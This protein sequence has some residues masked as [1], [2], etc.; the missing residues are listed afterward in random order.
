MAIDFMVRYWTTPQQKQL[1]KVQTKAIVKIK[2][3]LDR[4]EIGIP[5]PIR[6]VYHFNQ[7]DF[8]DFISV[9]TET[10]DN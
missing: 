7:E 8:N 6:T 3:A 5:Y 1:R 2:Q 9:K 4:A 10:S